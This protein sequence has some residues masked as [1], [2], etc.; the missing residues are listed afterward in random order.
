MD[1]GH[2]E[3][4]GTEHEKTVENSQDLANCAGY[5]NYRFGNQRVGI[6]VSSGKTRRRQL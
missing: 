1:L 4:G 2:L 5:Y 3:E 6:R